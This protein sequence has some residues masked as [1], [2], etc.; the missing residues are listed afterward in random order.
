MKRS[1]ALG[2]T[3]Q[4]AVAQGRAKWYSVAAARGMSYVVSLTSLTGSA[5]GL[6]IDDDGLLSSNLQPASPDH[7]TVRAAHAA[8][9]TH[10]IVGLLLGV[11]V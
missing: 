9:A 4:S 3:L 11:W 10:G 6:R 7:F 2:A 1:L 8:A 5:L